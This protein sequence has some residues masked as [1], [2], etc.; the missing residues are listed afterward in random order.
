MKLD[1]TS[2]GGALPKRSI[3]EWAKAAKEGQPG[4]LSELR[5]RIAASPGLLNSPRGSLALLAEEALLSQWDDLA[6]NGSILTKE[7]MRVKLRAME[8]ELAG[9]NPSPLELMLVERIGI[10]WLQANAAAARE[11]ISVKL[12]GGHPAAVFHGAQHEKAHRM[13]LS[14]IK[15]LAQVRKLQLPNIQINVGEKQVNVQSG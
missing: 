13:L 12:E 2:V 10:C 4:A 9:P 11:A 7:C 15:T 6:K 8:E 1:E 5:Q 14:A 3:E